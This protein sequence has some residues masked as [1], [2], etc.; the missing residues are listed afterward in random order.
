MSWTLCRRLCSL[1]SSWPLPLVILLS[2]WGG[3]APVQIDKVAGRGLAVTKQQRLRRPNTGVLA[4]NRSDAR[5]LAQES[6]AALQEYN[7]FV[8]ER[9]DFLLRGRRS[10]HSKPKPCQWPDIADARH[11]HLSRALPPQ[12]REPLAADFHHL[13]GPC[14]TLPTP[15]ET[16]LSALPT[17]HRHSLDTAA[18]F[19]DEQHVPR[20]YVVEADLRR[21]DPRSPPSS[22]LDRLLDGESPQEQRRR[23]DF[24]AAWMRAGD[25][26]DLH[27]TSF[28]AP[29][30]SEF[31]AEVS[32][33]AASRELLCSQR[34]S[35]LEEWRLG[36]VQLANI[37]ANCKYRLARTQLVQE[38]Q[39]SVASRR[40]LDEGGKV[41]MQVLHEEVSHLVSE[42]RLAQRRE[43]TLL[44]THS[45]LRAAAQAG[46]EALLV[47]SGRSI[48]GLSAMR[49]V[50]AGAKSSTA[51]FDTCK[52]E[53]RR[54]LASVEVCVETH[55]QPETIN[56][57]SCVGF[58]ATDR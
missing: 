28:D 39:G 57:F 7:R 3:I 8:S 12:Q 51:K 17:Q 43:L 13:Q 5:S 37:I 46:G 41:S 16:P 4:S 26:A 38:Q 33:L 6:A 21:Q 34:N 44:E 55:F 47:V 25:T 18:S 15:A 35:L 20:S 58:A 42:L 31:I 54:V 45:E 1:C 53:V 27:P 40:L 50:E 29:E 11:L 10:A 14:V 24:D 56:C 2:K 49:L 19:I 48:A 30:V 22:P 23:S 52:A 9:Y 32:R 36:A